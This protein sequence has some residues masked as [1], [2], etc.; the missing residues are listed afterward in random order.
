MWRLEEDIGED[1]WIDS[2]HQTFWQGAKAAFA[3]I[4]T[5]V[6]VSWRVIAICPF[7][8]SEPRVI[9]VPSCAD[10]GF[11]FI[12]LAGHHPRNRLQWL[13]HKLLPSS[14]EDVRV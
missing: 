5:Y 1:D 13:R 14:R 3:D 7:S 2:E 8:R 12:Y 11:L 9:F 4:K 10:R 6:L